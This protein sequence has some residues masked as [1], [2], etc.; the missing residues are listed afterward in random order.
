MLWALSMASQ[1]KINRVSDKTFYVVSACIKIFIV[2]MRYDWLKTSNGMLMLFIKCTFIIPLTDNSSSDRLYS[3]YLVTSGISFIANGLKQMLLC[4]LMGLAQHP[5]G[6]ITH[7][8]IQKCFSSFI[9]LWCLLW[10][11]CFN[12]TPQHFRGIEVRTLTWQS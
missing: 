12:I 9:F 8:S 10:I 6:I 5:G 4:L 2:W 3:E 11:S 7:S 1:C